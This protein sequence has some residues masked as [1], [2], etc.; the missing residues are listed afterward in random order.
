MKKD[1]LLPCV[2][3]KDTET[4]RRVDGRPVCDVCFLRDAALNG[5]VPQ[6]YNRYKIPA[7]ERSKDGRYR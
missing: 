3:C 2:V 1:K 7:R 5:G 4:Y 6:R